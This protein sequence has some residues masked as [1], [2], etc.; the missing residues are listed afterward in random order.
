MDAERQI[1]SD[2]LFMLTAAEKLDYPSLNRTAIQRILY[3]AAVLYPINGTEWGYPFTNAR[4][5]P[6][7]QFVNQSADRLVQL[8]LCK[9]DDLSV[10]SAG[11]IKASYSVTDPGMKEASRITLISVQQRRFNWIFSVLKALDIYGTSIISKLASI[12]PSYARMRAQNKIGV[13]DLGA[14]E[15]QSLPLLESLSDSLRK[16]FQIDTSTAPEKLGLYFDFLSSGLANS[17]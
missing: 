3:L 7:N 17:K 13:I 9:T 5:G 2:V 15:N 16:N 1:L 4:F 14:D 6:F 8:G 11:S 12:E 10:T